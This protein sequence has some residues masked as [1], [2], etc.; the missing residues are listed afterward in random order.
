MAPAKLMQEALF[1]MAPEHSF[2]IFCAFIIFLY[3]IFSLKGDGREL[4]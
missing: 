2:I 1:H 3:K 4:F